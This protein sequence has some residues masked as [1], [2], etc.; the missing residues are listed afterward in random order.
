[1]SQLCRLPDG[2]RIDRSKPLSFTFDGKSYIGFQG[3]TLAS[4]LLANGVKLLGRS[5]KYHRP[6]GLIAAG[7]EEPNALV[8][9]EK[10]A[11]TEPNTRATCIELYGGLV[12]TS[13]NR[14]PS[15]AFDVGAVNSAVARF[16]PAGFYYKTFMWP[17]SMWLTYEKFIRKA[18]GLGVSPKE[19][20]PDNYHSRYATC[21]V[22]VIGGGPAGLAAASAAAAS[23]ARV[24]LVDEQAEFGGST[25][26]A[27]AV[28]EVAAWVATCTAALTAN[29]N[30]TLLPR[31]TVTG[32]FDYNYL[33]AIE[34][35]T[36]HLGPGKG[37]SAPRQRFWKIRAKRVVIAAGSIER[38]LVFADNDRPGVMLANAVSSYINRYGVLPD[39]NIV[40]F[41][42]ND[43]A[44][45]T[46]LDA[47]QHGATVT[48]VDTRAEV[49][50]H[51]TTALKE[52][53][54]THFTGHAISSVQGAKGVTAV[55][56]M[57]LSADGKSLHGQ[58][59]E[60]DCGVVANSGGWTP[61]VHMFSQSGGK[62]HYDE[63]IEGFVPDAASGKRINPNSSAGACNGSFSTRKCMS[64]GAQ[65]GR[66]AASECGFAVV[67]VEIPDFA[68]LQI[69]E[70][71]GHIAA[72]W[73]V[74]TVHPVGEGP[75]KHFHDFQNDVTAADIQLAAREGYVSVEHL[76]RYTTTGMAT[77]QGKTSNL[78]ALAIM[79]EIRG[80]QIPEVGTTTFRPPF[81]PLTFGA[82]GGQESKELFLQ[83]RH[84]PMHQCHV[85]NN[86]V[87]EDVG[88][89]KR[90]WY[91]PR[92]G[93]D[94]RAAV[95]RESLAVRTDVGML[96]ASTLGKIDIQG[97]DAAEL[98]EMVYTN[99]WKKLAVGS[100]RYGLMLNEHGMIFDDGVT[101]RL[102]E[103]H[104]HMTTTTGGAARVLNWLEEW[105]QTEWPEKNVYCT[106][107]TEQ[108]AVVALNGPKA[109]ELLATVSDIDLANEAF[110][111]MTM[112][113]GHVAGIPAWVYR[114]S[115]TGELSYEINVPARYGRQLWQTLEQA[116]KPYNLCAYGTE[117][118]HVVRAEKGFII[119]GQD[120]DGTVTPADMDMS[121]IVS[122]TKDDFLGK[123]SFMRSD[124]ARDD[125]QQFVGL[126]TTD[127]SV[128][129]MEGAHIVEEIKE[130]PP[131]TTIGRVTSSYMSPNLG[132]SIALGMLKNGLSRKGDTVQLRLMSGD[133]VEA[134]VT[135]PV[136][137]DSE[138]VR[139]R[140]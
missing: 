108:W 63:A 19:S 67:E 75:A 128:V 79:A 49:A 137:I 17:A 76:K 41:T 14:W 105:L 120:T 84:T 23:D 82:I 99:N 86:A 123:R 111:F 89:W 55:R 73:L 124:T 96:D 39:N 87:F 122:K 91:Y 28:P 4:A 20:D 93:E 68:G 53:S 61:S 72:L 56:V 33:T 80:A 2:G 98:L 59:W 140:G 62:L 107:V 139:A 71:M 97:A 52:H 26:G 22:L 65:A 138:G 1:M 38:P 78:N 6:R 114:I 132:R 102:G 70:G 131:M 88:D 127:P 25:L 37:G 135:D 69:D 125:R 121:W 50:A 64:E 30:V 136:F 7:S 77:D 130:A 103:N 109:R 110:P 58:A 117:T 32:Y 118:M 29:E 44:Y 92:K 133:V 21:D 48:L 13:Q 74:P 90:P 27:S 95:Q 42:N 9:L 66:D 115:F 57:P 31:T 51:L 11:Y 24:M 40:V 106:S 104:Y 126:L 116:G 101:T 36:D 129:L 119:V 113:E 54:V 134:L 15:L 83:E 34:K 16:L 45:R 94:M 43:S 35:V 46:A 112:R 10:G 5:F 47:A 60:I 81:T 8:Q 3:D 100:C 18:A 12:A 85:Q